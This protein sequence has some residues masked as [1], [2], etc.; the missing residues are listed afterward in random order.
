MTEILAFS[1]LIAVIAAVA[2]FVGVIK[3]YKRG[4][5]SPIYPLKDYTKLDLT[6][7]DDIFINSTVTRVKVASSN[8]DKD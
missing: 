8:N 3:H 1:I 6:H 7:E 4:L 5:F 2:V